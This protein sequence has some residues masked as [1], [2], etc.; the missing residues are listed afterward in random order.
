MAPI[1]LIACFGVLFAQ[2]SRGGSISLVGGDLSVVSRPATFTGVGLSGANPV[3]FQEYANF[4][5][6]TFSD[7]NPSD[8]EL[9]GVDPQRCWL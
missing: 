4:Q 5:I 9:G 6:P 7:T 8:P 2:P 1:S 3:I